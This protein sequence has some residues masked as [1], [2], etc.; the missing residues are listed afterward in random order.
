ML[1]GSK[2][3]T[4]QEKDSY[5]LARSSSFFGGI[6]SRENTYYAMPSIKVEQEFENCCGIISMGGDVT[7]E[8]CTLGIPVLDL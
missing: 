4:W 6:Q 1:N 2:K 3:Y 8:A 5:E 7:Y